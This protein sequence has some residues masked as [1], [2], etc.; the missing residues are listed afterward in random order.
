MKIAGKEAVLGRPEPTCSTSHHISAYE[1][2]RVYQ[3]NVSGK[4]QRFHDGLG[5]QKPQAAT[6]ER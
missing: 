6:K 1:A 5:K 4:D 2:N 3:N